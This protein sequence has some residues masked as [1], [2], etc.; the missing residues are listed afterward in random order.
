MKVGWCDADNR[1]RMRVDRYLAADDVAP[2][3]EMVPPVVV[4]QHHNRVRSR[5]A[6]IRLVDRS[7]EERANA[8]N[9]EVRASHDLGVDRLDA[10]I[11][12]EGDRVRCTSEYAIEDIGL[13]AEVM[14]KGLR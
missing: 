5:L 14:I 3:T 11:N 12:A 10:P 7:S 8:E 2:A 6:I 4:R 1:H 9:L 13:I